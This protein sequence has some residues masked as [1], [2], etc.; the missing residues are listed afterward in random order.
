MSFFAEC[1]AWFCVVLAQLGLIALSGLS[2][3]H[4]MQLK[5]AHARMM[6]NKVS[7]NDA[8]VVNNE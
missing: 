4:L 2:G 1:I 7:E 6:A 8:V 5:E 3:Y